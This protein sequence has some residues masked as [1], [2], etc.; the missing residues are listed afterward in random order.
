M[1]KINIVHELPDEEKGYVWVGLRV[2]FWA[3]IVC[4]VVAMIE[5]IDPENVVFALLWVGLIIHTFVVS[6]IHLTKYK[7]KGLA[8]TS[9]VISSCLLFLVII[10]FMIGL[11]SV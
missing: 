2:G 3:M 5:L 8:V 9:L 11:M 4:W 7:Q 10:G 6:I 1:D